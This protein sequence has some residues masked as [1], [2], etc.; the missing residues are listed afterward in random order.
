MF[1]LIKDWL[2]EILEHQADTG[3]RPYEVCGIF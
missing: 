3:V 1:N 2:L